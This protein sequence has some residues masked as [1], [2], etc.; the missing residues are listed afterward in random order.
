M[1][2]T[3][4]FY[5]RFDIWLRKSEESMVLEFCG[6]GRVESVD[7]FVRGVHLSQIMVFRIEF[8]GV[9]GRGVD[10][11]VEV[12]R[13]ASSLHYLNLKMGQV[14]ALHSNVHLL[15]FVRSRAVSVSEYERVKYF[16]LASIIRCV[17][18]LYH[19]RRVSGTYDVVM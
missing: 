9:P 13:R 19:I 6:G 11:F 5:A 16:Y 12:H 3:L 18:Q 4:A 1:L 10:T 17:D 8:C 15:A 7:T 14:S 2:A